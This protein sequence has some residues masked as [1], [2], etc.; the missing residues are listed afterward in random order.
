MIKMKNLLNLVLLLSC[1]TIFSQDIAFNDVVSEVD[2]IEL[3]DKN[4]EA[5]VKEVINFDRETL[6]IEVNSSENEVVKGVYFF[7]KNRKLISKMK[8]FGKKSSTKFNV[9]GVSL[10]N[11]VTDKGYHFTLIRKK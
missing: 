2:Y 8:N 1:T 6:K 5:P 9:E 10:V 7:D 3:A 4:T 11:V